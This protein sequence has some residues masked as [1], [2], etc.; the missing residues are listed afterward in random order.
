MADLNFSINWIS[1]DSPDPIF[2]DT[3]AQL[4]IALSN[5]FLTQ[6]VDVW[7]KTV[8][9]SVLV[10]VY[11]LALWFASSWWRLN[12][13]PLPA[14]GI[15]PGFS[16][17]MA[18]ELGAANHGFVWPRILFAP[19]GESMNIWAEPISTPGQSVNYTTRLDKL[20]SLPFSEVQ[21]EIDCFIEKTISRLCSVR[22]TENDLAELWKIIKEDRLNPDATQIRQL[23][24]RMGFDP[25]ECPVKILE[26]A[27]RLQECTGFDA[28]K[29]LAPVFGSNMD[30]VEAL[31]NQ[32]GLQGIPQVKS[33]DIV[34]DAPSV[35]AP[36]WKQGVDVAR[37][38]RKEH[39]LGTDPIPY[40]KLLE[41]LG[42]SR[43]NAESWSY[44]EVKSSVAI[45]KPGDNGRWIFIPRRGG[46]NGK[47]FEL[48]RFLGDI[49]TKPA[50]ASA[51]DWLVSSDL[52]TARQKRQRAFAAEFLCPI[53]ALDDFLDGDY[54]EAMREDAAIHF[55][56]SEQTITSL[57]ANNSR[58]ERIESSFPYQPA[59]S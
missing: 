1:S 54:S 49:L 11:P 19:D 57:L 24:A 44:P 31:Q 37:Q 5:T 47:R 10:S 33:S 45:A 51:H 36:P 56:V 35:F 41:L 46:Q 59:I 43:K 2:R 53:E 3:S 21:N 30:Q 28:M 26:E 40:T 22:C 14:S 17:R 55:N 20:H 38:L 13:E 52:V 39:D 32:S 18:H 27:M 9:D 29:E 50:T 16:W 23:E 48:A 6:N 8:S 58:I 25:E 42:I 7:S 34:I 15:K 4:S 12:N